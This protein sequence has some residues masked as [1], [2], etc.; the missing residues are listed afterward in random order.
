M[1]VK[2]AIGQQVIPSALDN[3]KSHM[4]DNYMFKSYKHVLII[5]IRDYKSTTTPSTNCHSITKSVLNK[6][7]PSTKYVINIIKHGD[8]HRWN[9]LVLGYKWR[10]CLQVIILEEI[11]LNDRLKICKHVIY[12]FKVKHISN[13]DGEHIIYFYGPCGGCMCEWHG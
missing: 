5:F 7:I 3:E 1:L 12:N 9:R 11:V 4:F 8:I 6:M 10:Y 2:G 13:I